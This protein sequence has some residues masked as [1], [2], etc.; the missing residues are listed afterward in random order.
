VGKSDRL[1]TRE[2][3]LRRVGLAGTADRKVWEISR[4]QQQRVAIAR[5]LAA[6]TPL[7]LLDEP[8]AALDAL[9][10]ERLQEDIRTVSHETAR[11]V[12]R[13]SPEYAELRAQ[14]GHV[15][16]RRRAEALVAPARTRQGAGPA[17]LV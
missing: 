3:L 1:A 5:A 12:L 6:H 17:R 10:R 9:T 4:G 7:L 13:G 16:K 14:V 2:G 8:F 11:T 15:V